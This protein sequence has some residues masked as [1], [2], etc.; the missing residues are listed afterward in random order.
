VNDPKSKLSRRHVFAG[1]GTAGA[2]AVV[3]AALPRTT[4]PTAPAAKPEPVAAQEGGYQ[5]TQHV[6]QYYQTARV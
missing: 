6:L 1:A 4:Q 5:V 3:A 2:L